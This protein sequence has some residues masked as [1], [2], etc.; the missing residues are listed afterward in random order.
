MKKTSL[1]LITA[2]F[3]VVSCQPAPTIVLPTLVLPT[4]TPPLTPT[5]IPPSPTSRPT[6]DLVLNEEFADPSSFWC[7]KETGAKIDWYCQDGELHAVSKDLHSF[8][9]RSI[10]TPYKDFIMQ[11]QVRFVG[12]AGSAALVFRATLGVQPSMYVSFVCPTGCGS[13]AKYS[14]GKQSLLIPS[15][16]LPAIKQE[17]T[18][19]LQIVAQGSRFTFY[20]NN[21]EL[22]RYNDASYSEGQLGMGAADGAHVVF[23]NL[24]IW[25]PNSP[26]P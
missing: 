8:Q 15:T 11:V 12:D 14:E 1:L 24:K 26:A 2:L 25:V 21:V 9:W 23:D 7:Q 19:T 10:R 3:I 4:S 5:S 6:A 22:A 18:N 17:A 16:N 13:L 20:A